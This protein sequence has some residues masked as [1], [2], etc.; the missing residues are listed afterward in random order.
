MFTNESIKIDG[1][2][3]WII[4]FAKLIYGLSI[5][6]FQIIMYSSSIFAFES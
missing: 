5:L 2:N 6:T 1:E 4:K 3:K